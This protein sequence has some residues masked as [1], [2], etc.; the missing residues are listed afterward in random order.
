MWVLSILSV[1][2]SNNRSLLTNM[3]LSHMP[4]SEHVYQD[5]YLCV[6]LHVSVWWLCHLENLVI[7][8][9]CTEIH[10]HC[11]ECTWVKILRLYMCYEKCS[12]TQS[13]HNFILQMIS[14][15]YLQNKVVFDGVYLHCL[16][17]CKYNGDE[18][19]LRLYTYS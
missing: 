9:W 10:N 15:F 19:T 16:L 5:M 4:F 7:F 1:Q 8:W 12:Y 2:T 11:V 17:Y 14:A 3:C 18:S 13:R 6:S